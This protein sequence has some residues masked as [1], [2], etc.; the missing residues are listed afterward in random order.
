[1]GYYTKGDY[2]KLRNK[3]EKNKIIS[4]TDLRKLDDFMS[5]AEYNL[6]GK[7]VKIN[8]EKVEVMT[9]IF[10]SAVKRL[11]KLIK[12]EEENRKQVFNE[13]LRSLANIYNAN[14]PKNK[15]YLINVY[16]I[17]SPKSKPYKTSNYNTSSSKDKL[18]KIPS[19][20]EANKL[21]LSTQQMSMLGNSMMR[22]YVGVGL[23]G[24][25]IMILLF[26]RK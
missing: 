7:K 5:Y 12:T 2:F 9:I 16:D 6:K 17:S 13:A 18:Y 19:G 3:I 8:N 20:N 1:M 21:E 14:S 10:D 15:L 25:A 23:I 24:L 11:M 4:S 22:K 26:G